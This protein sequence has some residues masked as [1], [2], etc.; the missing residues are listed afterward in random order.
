MSSEVSLPGPAIRPGYAWT[1]R[2]EDGDGVGVFPVDSTW[3]SHV[4]DYTAAKTILVDL[5]TEDGGIERISDTVLEIRMSAEQTAVITNALVV[6]DLTRTDTDP[7]V[8]LGPKFAVS[9]DLT[10]TRNLA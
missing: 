8:P 1:L 10:V 9:V 7:M 3:R 4:R 2:I 6:F 5:S